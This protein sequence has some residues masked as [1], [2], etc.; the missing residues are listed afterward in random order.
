M[1]LPFGSYRRSGTGSVQRLLN[2]CAEQMPLG[3]KAPTALI[4]T[5]GIRAHKDVGTGPGRG[6]ALHAGGLY[7]VSGSKLYSVPLSG[8]SGSATELGDVPGSQRASLA[9]NGTTLVVVKNPEAY[10]YNG[11]NVAEITDT[12]FTSRGAGKVD[13]IDGYYVFNE[14]NTGR[15]FSSDLYALTFDA[16]K[17]GTAEGSPDNLLDFIVTLREILF[18]GN[19]TGELWWNSGAGNYPF[20]RVAN[21]VIEQGIKSGLTKQDNRPFWFA[22][23]NTFR[24]LNG[25]IAQRVSTHSVEEKL[26]GYA[27]ACYAFAY[28]HEGHAVVVFK[29]P[30]EATWC[31]DITTGEFHERAS[32]GQDDWRIVDAI[33]ISGVTYVQDGETGK[34]GILDPDTYAEWDDPLVAQFMYPSVYSGG[35]IVFHNRF[36]LILETGVG[37]STGQGSNPEV[38]LECSDDGGKTWFSAP[39]RTIGAI[40]Q[41]AWRVEWFSLGASRDRVYRVSIS[42]PVRFNVHDTVLDAEIGE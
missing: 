11:T 7:A 29:F 28:T 26:R 42:D 8:T 39:N 37:L 19:K 33:E 6:L 40:G 3:G 34:V 35:K 25:N 12:D 24:A 18:L 30:G 13:F 31:L 16:L 36:E 4:R 9:S 23:D 38:M 1:L 5:P 32:Y 2:C 10:R 22:N 20:E 17:F 21:G 41:Y 27:S 14:P 15:H